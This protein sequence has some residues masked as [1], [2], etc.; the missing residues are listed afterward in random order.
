MPS[1]KKLKPF[2]ISYLIRRRTVQLL[3][4]RTSNRFFPNISSLLNNLPLSVANAATYHAVID[5]YSISLHLTLLLRRFYQLHFAR[6]GCLVRL[7]V[8]Q[9][10]YKQI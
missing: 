3:T 10:S 2:T 5:L 9:E 1:D 6:G 4:N 8:G 7:S